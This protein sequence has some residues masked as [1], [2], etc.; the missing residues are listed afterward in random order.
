MSSADRKTDFL[1]RGWGF[2][3]TF[4]RHRGAVAMVED[5]EDIRQ[6]LQIL[7]STSLRERIL[8]PAY[9]CTLQDHVFAPLEPMLLTLLEDLIAKAILYC[10]PRIRV[11]LIEAE[12]DPVNDGQVNIRVAYTIRTSNTRSNMVYPFYL[13][14]GSL[15]RRIAHP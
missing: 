14:E 8:L 6:S 15:V 12:A 4:E 11:E 5:E 7:F 1:G 13:A 2:P 9:G 10:E 3:P